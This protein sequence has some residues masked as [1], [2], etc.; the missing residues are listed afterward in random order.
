MKKL[1]FV[2]SAAILMFAACSKEASREDSTLTCATRT[3][4]ASIETPG[5]K[6]TIAQDGDYYNTLWSSGD[7]IY[8][9]VNDNNTHQN[10]VF[11]TTDNGTSTATFTTQGSLSAGATMTKGALFPHDGDKLNSNFS[12]DGTDADGNAYFHLLSEYTWV[13]GR[14]Y[15]PLLADM[16]D[17]TGKLK[18]YHVAGGVL[19]TLQNIPPEANKV[20]LTIGDYNICGWSSGLAAASAGTVEIAYNAL[21]DPE[22]VVSF[23][24]GK[25]TATTTKT[26]LFPVATVPSSKLTI[27]VKSDDVV[28]WQKTTPK[29]Q[30]EIAR[31]TILDMGTVTVSANFA[32]V[33][34]ITGSRWSGDGDRAL[35][36]YGLDGLDVP[37]AWPGIV[38]TIDDEIGGVTFRRFI[39]PAKSGTYHAIYNN[40]S[41]T[42]IYQL[43][44]DDITTGSNTYIKTDGVSS[45]SSSNTTLPGLESET[46]KKIWVFTG[47]YTNA[48]FWQDGT[49]NNNDWPG[50]SL[51]FGQ[52]GKLNNAE[53]RW[54]YYEVTN[55]SWDRVIFN[56]GSNANQ[57]GNLE[58]SYDSLPVFFN[59]GD[60][61]N[62]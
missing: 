46:G 39:L 12:I 2:F 32:Y 62:W 15:L 61:L 24:F 43:S 21:G 38:S 60:K 1:F 35:Y 5:T 52:E 36:L 30:P 37:K 41:G 33:Q 18:F 22:K 14:S 40:N 17:G 4:V 27:Q 49:E 7:Q 8:V 10:V 44:L 20:S 56:I 34:D 23:S 26:F 51:E 13:Q 55:A 19:V 53:G 11:S 25:E 29:A 45:S 3:L 28:I 31:G 9:Y 42:S 59:D 6:A 50:S 48:Y 58:Y 54:K 47:A 16:S 57:T